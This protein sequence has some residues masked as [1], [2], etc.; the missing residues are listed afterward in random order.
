M[1]T[2][3]ITL[4]AVVLIMFLA[5]Q[6]GKIIES[7]KAE[8]EDILPIPV[9][10][11]SIEEVSADLETEETI[12]PRYGFTEEDIY[13]L[14]QLLCGDGGY[15]GD[16]EYDFVYGA[17]HDEMRYDEMAKV[18]C[19]VM[20]RVRSDE[21]PDTVAEVVLQPDQFANYTPT[22]TTPSDI[23]IEKV[24]EWCEAYDRWDGGVQNIPEDHLYYEAG[25]DLT[26]VTREEL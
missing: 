11:S 7:M 10:L 23:A 21:F 6:Q 4:V 24:R 8:P 15:N 1:K 18:L 5:V 22:D 26:N 2:F 9:V 12:K 20:N 19:V 3:L 16:G 17:L 25:P 14:A 13:L